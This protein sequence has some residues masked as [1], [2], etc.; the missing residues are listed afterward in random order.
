AQRRRVQR[1]WDDLPAGA[2]GVEAGVAG[3][4][5][6]DHLAEGGGELA[7]LLGADEARQRLLDQLRRPGAQELRDGGGGLQDL[8][9][10]VGDEHRVG[11]V[12]DDDVGPEGAIRPA[13]LEAG[14]VWRGLWVRDHGTFFSKGYRPD[15]REGYHH[16]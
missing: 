11:G 15:E 6:G 9:L 5:L 12:G 7:R 13:V 2:S 4:A 10:Q 1:R 3:D 14:Q 16:V 8:A